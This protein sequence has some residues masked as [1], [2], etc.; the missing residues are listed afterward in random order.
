LHA[1]LRVALAA[2]ERIEAYKRRLMDS[3]PGLARYALNL[4]PAFQ[5]AVSP[6][7]SLI[8]DVPRHNRRAR[9]VT[10]L[11]TIPRAG[12]CLRDYLRQDSLDPARINWF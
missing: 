5:T 11:A 4:S 6:V 2:I 12:C 10:D 7:P 9:G 8:R 3:T 1:E